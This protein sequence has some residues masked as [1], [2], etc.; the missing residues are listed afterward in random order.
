MYKILCAVVCAALTQTHAGLV[1][2]DNSELTATTGQGGADLSWTLSLNHQ[3]ANDMSKNNISIMD[4]SGKT[5]QA[6]YGY[7]CSSNEFCR[8][9]LAPNNHVDANGNKKWLV[10]KQFQG[11]LQIDQFSLDGVTIINREGNPQTAMQL[12]F[13]DGKPLKIRNLGF[14]TLAVET[15]ATGKE[16]YENTSTYTTYT[17]KKADGTTSTLAVPE[18]DRGSEQGFM[19]VNVHGNMHMSGK[20]NIFSFNCTGNSAGRC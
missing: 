3:Y 20:L 2:M 4:A 11:T 19:G 14:A 1:S 12:T 10:F 15:G 9:A 7:Q 6:F 13:Y 16:G 8:L 17:E 5:T 18:F